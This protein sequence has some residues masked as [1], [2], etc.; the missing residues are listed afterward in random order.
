MALAPNRSRAFVRMLVVVMLG[1]AVLATVLI[2]RGMNDA[3]LQH[4]VRQLEEM[5]G[6]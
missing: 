4:Q 3:E 1:L 6:R 2:T 5:E